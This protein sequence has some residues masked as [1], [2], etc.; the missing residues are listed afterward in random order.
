MAIITLDEVRNNET[1]RTYLQMAN[2]VL[3][4]M[5]YTEHGLR[6]AGIVANNARRLCLK[7][8]YTERQAELAAI[9]GYLHDIG[10]V[11]S[12]QNHAQT[13][14]LIAFHLLTQMGMPPEEIAIIVSAIGNHEETSG[15]PVNYAAATVILADK[16]D[17]HFSRV[18][19]PN[20]SA[21]DI[22]DRV[23]FA[24]QR[25][26]LRVMPKERI[27]ELNLEIDTS[28]AS[29]MEYFEIFLDRMVMCRRAAEALECQFH[30]MINGA[31]IG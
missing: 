4:A 18:Q 2:Q 3:Y 24:T 9:A 21:F 20:R 23:N 27:I 11:V 10:N 8:G 26:R 7:L 29:L 5:G 25:S 19:N 15:Y 6:H 13:G 28:V 22:H 14:A 17:V 30:L 31:P 12:R 1:V 16:S